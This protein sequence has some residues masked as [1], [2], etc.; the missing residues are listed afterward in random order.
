MSPTSRNFESIPFGV[1]KGMAIILWNEEDHV[2]VLC[3]ISEWGPVN[4]WL[5]QFVGASEFHSYP[6]TLTSKYL[7][8]P[9]YKASVNQYMGKTLNPQISLEV[10]R[11]L[12]G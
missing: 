3:F 10:C 7:A 8:Q 12:A 11:L 1:T 4:A 5:S 6:T 9:S 2:T